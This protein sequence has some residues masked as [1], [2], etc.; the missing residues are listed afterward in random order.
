MRRTRTRTRLALALAAVAVGCG[1]HGDGATSA[2]AGAPDASPAAPYT[3]I[4]FDDARITSRGGEPNFQR[5]TAPV[6]LVDGPFASVTL[7]VD[8]R[9]TCYPFESWQTNPPP[10][11]HRWP[12]DCDAFDRNFELTFDGEVE[13]VRAITPFGGPLHL[14]VDVTDFANGRPGAHELEAFIA[15]WSDAS[16]QVTGADGGWNVSARLEVVP[17]PPPRRVLAVIPLVNGGLGAEGPP[18]PVTFDVP[19]GTTATRLEYR[20]TGHGGGTGDNECLGPAEEFCARFHHVTI[21]GTEVHDDYLVPWRYDCDQLCTVAHYGP[22]GGG[23][24]YCL[25]NPCGA[26][27]SVRAPR[28]NWCPGSLTPPFTWDPPALRTPGPHTFAVA[29]DHVAPGGSWRLSAV[30]YAFGE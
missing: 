28:A 17:G 3:I 9:S 7:V 26:I 2:D 8:L 1:G 14:E 10:P 29:V 30:V 20:A 16:G 21:D 5:I 22:P 15:T 19:E 12:A 13:V 6:D 24:D 4:A 11:G 27:Q 23:F 18:A 25:E